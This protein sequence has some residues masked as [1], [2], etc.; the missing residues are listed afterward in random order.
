M[1]L[2]DL[3]AAV[4]MLR[5]PSIQPK[6]GKWYGVSKPELRDGIVWMGMCALHPMTFLNIF[7]EDYFRKIDK[8]CSEE[9]IEKFIKKWRKRKK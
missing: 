3:R 9:L 4:K 6:N 1:K 8:D 7:G 5:G 2:E